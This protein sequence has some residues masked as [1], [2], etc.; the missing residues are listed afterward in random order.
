M[1]QLL[2]LTLALGGAPALAA[3]EA[4]A[5]AQVDEAALL[6]RISAKYGDVETMKATFQQTST[7]A[8]YGASSEQGT[9]TLKRPRKMRWSFDG[10]GK[11]FITDG[12]T[13]WIYAPADKQVIR[14]EDFGGQGSAPDQLLQ[15]LDKLGEL[16]DV[17]VLESGDEGHALSLMPLDEAARAQVKAVKLWLDGDL[18]VKKVE[19]TDAYDGVT[20]LGFSSVTLGGTVD[21]AQFQF[22]I[23]E[24]V[25]V[26]DAKG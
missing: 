21:D 5:A 16:F 1:F 22:Q 19:V 4:P 26:V 20:T 23:P 6:K 8:L 9:L 17:E 13:M 15:S 12:A 7:S 3:D 10:D 18:V 11:Q 14:Y 25:D 2:A 24:G